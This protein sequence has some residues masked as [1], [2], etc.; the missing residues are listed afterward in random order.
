[1][2]N[3]KTDECG[4]MCASGYDIVWRGEGYSQ[5]LLRVYTYI[6]T[7]HDVYIISRVLLFMLLNRASL[8]F[9]YFTSVLPPRAGNKIAAKL[10]SVLGEGLRLRPLL[11][12]TFKPLVHYHD[13]ETRPPGKHRGGDILFSKI[14]IQRDQL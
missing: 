4:C 12:I 1:M 9:H 5:Q 10:P 8:F 11:Y 7:Q 6:R 14:Y 3:F 13:V 2:V